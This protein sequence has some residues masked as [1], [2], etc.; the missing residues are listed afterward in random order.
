MSYIYR[1][2][3][4]CTLLPNKEK[5]D[6]DFLSVKKLPLYSFP[7]GKVAIYAKNKKGEGIFGFGEI[8]NVKPFKSSHLDPEQKI[9]FINRSYFQ[10]KIRY[11]DKSCWPLINIRH[12]KHFPSFNSKQYKKPFNPFVLY[13]AGAM[14]WELS[15]LQYR[16]SHD[17][18]SGSG[19]GFFLSDRYWRFYIH[20]LREQ[21]IN[22]FW[23]KRLPK[24]NS[25]CT[26]CGLKSDYPYFLEIHDTVKIDF[27]DDYRPVDSKNF[28]V[29][30]PNCH[31]K[32]H[33]QMRHNNDN[34]I[35][36]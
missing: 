11:R 28:I 27:D 22:Y 4:K 23:N 36:I 33:L 16:F 7:L 8:L 9:K 25:R 19:L 13:W 24:E 12:L 14:H 26:A 10:V 6:L 3:E 1:L 20:I 18:N 29:L 34:S 35:S 30:C 32:E 31:K 5:F 2:P 17:F 15:F 21:W